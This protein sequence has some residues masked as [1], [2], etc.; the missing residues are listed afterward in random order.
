MIDRPGHPTRPPIGLRIPVIVA[1]ALP[2]AH[3]RFDACLEALRVQRP[4]EAE[5]VLIQNGAQAKDACRRWENPFPTARAWTGHGAIVLRPGRNLGAAGGWNLGLQWAFERGHEVA[6]ILGDDVIL[7][8]TWT[9]TIIREAFLLHRRQ[10]RALRGLGYSGVCIS[11]EVW[12]EIGPFDEGFWP[13][14]FEDNDHHTR[15]KLI[16]IP[17]DEIL[18]QTDHGA[19]SGHLRDSKMA[20]LNART[21]PLNRDRYILKWGGMPHYETYT[22]PWNGGPPQTGT[23]E[24][25][26]PETRAMIE[27]AE[28]V[29]T[30][31]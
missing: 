16:G 24:R 26:D 17:W 8:D 15:C 28:Q 21:F 25:L 4:V 29:K 3:G 10:L 13:S 14:Y 20:S 31:A 27:M 23:R 9:L 7:H 18:V 22:V 6:L 19:G 2:D 1:T 12:D 5:I 30:R 11:R